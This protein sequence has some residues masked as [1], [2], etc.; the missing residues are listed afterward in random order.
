MTGRQLRVLIAPD[1]FKGSLTSVQVARA[2]ADGWHRAR[3]DDDIDL[4]PLADG[5][6]GTLDRD[7]GRRRLAVA[8]GRRDRSART[9]DP[10]PRWLRRD[11]GTGAVVEL[12]DGVRAVAA[13]RPR[14]RDAARRHDLGHRRPA[15]RRSLGGASGDIVL[16]I[17]GSATTDGGAGL[18]RSL[19]RRR[20]ERRPRDA[21]T[22]AGS[23]R[24][25]RE[26]SARGSPPT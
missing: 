8:P 4:A 10:T 18:L 23:T 16:G 2:I 14:E 3:P 21:W 12:A 13:S 6:E 26:T 11:D 24:G 7:R 25:C 1:S 15:A 19:G 22:S 5:G 17:G 9:P 20:V